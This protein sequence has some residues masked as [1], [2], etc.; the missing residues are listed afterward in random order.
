MFFDP[1]WRSLNLQMM[2]FKLKIVSDCFTSYLDS[3]ASKNKQSYTPKYICSI[4]PEL[5]PPYATW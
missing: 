3:Q 4:G 1:S 2:F 5:N